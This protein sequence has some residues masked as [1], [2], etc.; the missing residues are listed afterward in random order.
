MPSLL[1]ESTNSMIIMIPASHVMTS[2]MTITTCTI[3]NLIEYVEKKDFQ[4]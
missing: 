2:F 3:L 1:I 4:F